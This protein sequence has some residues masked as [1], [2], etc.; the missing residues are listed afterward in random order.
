MKADEYLVPIAEAIEKAFPQAERKGKIITRKGSNILMKI[1]VRKANTRMLEPWQ[2]AGCWTEITLEIR[3]KRVN[4]FFGLPASQVLFNGSI[5]SDHHSNPYYWH[6]YDDKLDKF[7]EKLTDTLSD[8][9][10][11]NLLEQLEDSDMV[12]RILWK[13]LE[14]DFENQTWAIPEVSHI[15]PVILRVEP[16]V[17]NLEATAA[18]YAYCLLQRNDI[19]G[20]KEVIEEAG[21]FAINEEEPTRDKVIATIEEKEGQGLTIIPLE[22]P[23]K[24]P[25]EEDKIEVSGEVTDSQ[26]LT[27]DKVKRP[28]TFSQEPVFAT[29]KRFSTLEWVSLLSVAKSIEGGYSPEI[30]KQLQQFSRKERDS[31]FRFWDDLRDGKDLSWLKYC[32]TTWPTGDPLPAE[33][34]LWVEEMEGWNFEDKEFNWELPNLK[35]IVG[36]SSYDYDPTKN[37]NILI[38]NPKVEQLTLSIKEE[39]IASLATLAGIENIKELTLTSNKFDKGLGK[40]IKSKK[41]ENLESLTLKGD[42]NPPALTWLLKPNTFPMLK[43][44]ELGDMSYAQREKLAPKLHEAFPNLEKLK[45]DFSYN[46]Q[47]FKLPPKIEHLEV[48]ASFGSFSNFME[49]NQTQRLKTFYIRGSAVDIDGAKKLSKWAGISELEQLSIHPK[50]DFGEI[51]SILS[52]LPCKNLQLLD[53]N[54]YGLDDESIDG[55]L[56]LLQ[57]FPNLEAFTLSSMA[58]DASIKSMQKLMPALKKVKSIYSD[59]PNFNYALLQEGNFENLSY[60]NLARSSTP[61]DL[62]KEQLSNFNQ[63]NFPQLQFLAF[64]GVTIEADTVQ[65]LASSDVPLMGLSFDFGSKSDGFTHLSNPTGLPYLRYLEINL[66]ED[67]KPLFDKLKKR[68]VQMSW[69]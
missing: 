12:E 32:K 2:R 54:L 33:K 30:D 58:S 19:Q 50:A 57:A 29:V 61:F 20:A 35:S 31:G 36:S 6:C 53:I 59:V 40:L 16:E 8:N 43:S 51:F 56:Q 39:D 66:S 22:N 4:K 25:V 64:A 34:M 45:A 49:I 3:D 62:N 21:G 18:I 46:M 5:Y 67:E 68:K 24:V 7:C 27:V 47:D 28:A 44:L 9:F 26:E 55:L 11:E 52:T 41:L 42:L 48:D 14:R 15:E 63:V 17:F 65:K 1:K 60:L 13:Q 23:K 38:N 10:L 69:C 37:Q